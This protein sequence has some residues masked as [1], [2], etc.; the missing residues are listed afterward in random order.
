KAA[1]EAEHVDLEERPAA[2]ERRADAEA[3]DAVIERTSHALQANGVDAVTQRAILRQADVSRREPEA[4]PPSLT[5]LD[6]ADDEP[7]VPE[8]RVG[9]CHLAGSEG[10]PDI[11][12]GNQRAWRQRD[13]IDHDHAEAQPLARL[14]QR[15]GIAGA[16][17]AG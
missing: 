10:F 8:D 1:A 9:P 11:A 16:A 2:S 14:H 3:R 4:P 7:A 6:R 5:L 17:V 15:R 12:R 13:R